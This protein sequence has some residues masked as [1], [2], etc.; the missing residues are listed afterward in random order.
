[1]LSSSDRR[2]TLSTHSAFSFFDKRPQFIC[3]DDVCRN[4]LNFLIVNHLGFIASGTNHTHTSVMSHT[5]NSSEFVQ[6]TA[7][8]I[9]VKACLNSLSRNLTAIIEGIKG[10]AEGL[11]AV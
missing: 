10:F 3:I 11:V 7:L 2:S 4:S 9:R 6:T 5:R 1:M 8:S